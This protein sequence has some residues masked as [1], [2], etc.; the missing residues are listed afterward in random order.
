MFSNACSEGSED[1][2]SKIILGDG[3]HLGG[4]WGYGGKIFLGG[5]EWE[6]IFWK[7]RWQKQLSKLF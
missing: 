2:N 3:M 5:M 7:L 1:W 6:Q 4:G